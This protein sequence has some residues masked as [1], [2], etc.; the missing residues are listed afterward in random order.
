MSR[1]ASISAREFETEAIAQ[2]SALLGVASRLTRNT[3]DAQDLVQDTL[4][5]A[6]RARDQFESGTNMRAWLLRI[7][8]NTFINRY[9]RGGLERSVLDHGVD[10]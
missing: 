2:L 9:R 6:M 7:L 8:T 3:A 10:A 1:K 4:L 5:K